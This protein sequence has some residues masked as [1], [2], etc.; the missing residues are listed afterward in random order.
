M[1]IRYLDPLGLRVFH[2][3]GSCWTFSVCHFFYLVLS[4]EWGNGSL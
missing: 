1:I 4:R 2:G 3:A